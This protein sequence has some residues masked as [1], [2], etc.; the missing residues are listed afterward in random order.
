M[1]ATFEIKYFQFIRKHFNE[2]RVMRDYCQSW[3]YISHHYKSQHA[4]PVEINPKKLGLHFATIKHKEHS[5]A[6]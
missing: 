5:Q 2:I 3:S 1:N 6:A 4:G